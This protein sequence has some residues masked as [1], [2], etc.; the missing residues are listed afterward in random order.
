MYPPNDTK[1]SRDSSGSGQARR[2]ARPCTALRRWQH[3]GSGF[4]TRDQRS[5]TARTR[6]P[7][8]RPTRRRNREVTQSLSA[9]PHSQ[10]S[11][12]APSRAR[13]VRDES[14]ELRLGRSN[15]RSWPRERDGEFGDEA[16]RPGRHDQHAVRQENRFQDA[17][18]DE[19]YRLAVRHPDF[20]QLEAHPLAGKRIER[21][22]G[23]V[24][25]QHTRIVD[26]ELRDDADA[27]LHAAG[28]L[29]GIFVLET[30]SSPTSASSS[31]A[32]SPPALGAAATRGAAAAHSR[33]PSARAVALAS[34]KPRPCRAAA[35][36]PR[37]RDS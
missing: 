5:P 37:A 12:D 28:E 24:H 19:E 17:V 13:D 3:I 14:V 6:A 20:L 33:A 18:R 30:R 11:T 35:A 2:Q 15:R 25:E 8:C 1:S 31:R 32:R 22:K 23:L 4:Q 29:E 7:G 26:S 34:G 10:A 9:P 16:A 36:S 27:L 21:A